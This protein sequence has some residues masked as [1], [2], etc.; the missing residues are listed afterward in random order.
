MVH[1][2]AKEVSIATN[3]FPLLAQRKKSKEHIMKFIVAFVAALACANMAAGHFLHKEKFG[4]KEPIICAQPAPCV[5]E[6]P[7]PV[8]VLVKSPPKII[9]KPVKVPVAV[10]V[11]VPCEKP[12]ETPCETPCY[13][14]PV[15]SCCSTPV[16]PSCSYSY[17]T[18][19]YS[20]PCSYSS[21]VIYY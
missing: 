16:E 19:V 4:C 11:P 5:V 8:P 3:F 18:P 15:E 10:P 6:K 17:S 21:P 13:S 1:L 9:E 2:I 14:T 12:C 7:V 20:S